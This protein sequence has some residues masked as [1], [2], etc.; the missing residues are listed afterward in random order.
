MYAMTKMPPRRLT[1]IIVF[2]LVEAFALRP[3]IVAPF[4]YLKSP[5]M[6]DA[7]F[8]LMVLIIGGAIGYLV[9]VLI[10]QKWNTKLWIKLVVACG[11]VLVSMIGSYTISMA[12]DRS[13][14]QSYYN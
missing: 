9:G 12:V 14:V 3:A 4:H 13:I 7:L 5:I 1:A 10:F 2:A 6:P 8:T 11:I